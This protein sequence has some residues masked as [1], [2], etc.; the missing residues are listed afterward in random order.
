MKYGHKKP[1]FGKSYLIR[2]HFGVNF[3][4]KRTKI[5]PI[6]VRFGSYWMLISMVKMIL[7]IF[8]H[9]N[10]HRN[11]MMA[12]S[13]LKTSFLGSEN[14]FFRCFEKKFRLQFFFI[15]LLNY[16]Y[17]KK[18]YKHKKTQ[19][20]GGLAQSAGRYSIF[21]ALTVKNWR[22]WKSW[23]FWLWGTYFGPLQ[24]LFI[25]HTKFWC[26][27]CDKL[28]K[29]PTGVKLGGFLGIWKISCTASVLRFKKFSY[30]PVLMSQGGVF[31]MGVKP[32]NSKKCTT[33]V[34]WLSDYLT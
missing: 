21:G 2:N 1:L 9:K 22:N 8:L 20:F 7:V 13:C 26:K 29:V 4:P 32:P 10:C 17:G 25:I 12:I 19:T 14:Q 18:W 28:T 11:Q 6:L 16:K 34:L 31:H 33:N 15:F 24:T 3:G 23:E 30:M 27:K 5:D